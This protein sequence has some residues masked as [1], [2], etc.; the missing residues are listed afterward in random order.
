MTHCKQWWRAALLAAALTAGAGTWAADQ[1]YPGV[2][3]FSRWNNIPGTAVS[4]L[5]SNPR[6]PSSPDEITFPDIPDSGAN[7]GD[8]YGG[9]IEFLWSP[10]TSGSYQFAISADDNAEL[11][12]S[13][14]ENPANLVRVAIEPEWNGHRA[15]GTAE[16]RGG[17]PPGEGGVAACPNVTSPITFQAGRRYLFVGLWK[18]GGGGDSFAV[19]AGPAGTVFTDGMDPIPSSEIGVMASNQAAFLGNARSS[20]N[21]VYVGRRVNLA[22]NLYTPP[23]GTP[24]AVQWLKN[25]TPIPGGTGASYDYTAVAADAN[26][27]L[28]FSARLPD[29]TTSSTVTVRGL[30]VEGEVLSPGFLKIEFFTGIGGTAIDD[31]LNAPSF[32]NNQ[33]D[34]VSYLSAFDTPN[35][36]GDN[37]GARVTGFIIP[38]E[39]ADYHFFIRSDD[40]S[41]LSI[42]TDA[43][44]ANLQV[45]AQEFG[46]CQAFQEVD[47]GANQTT[48]APIRMVAGQRYYVEA[49][50]KEGGGGDYL[51]VAWRKANTSTPPAA[52]LQPIPGTFLATMAESGGV[53]INFTQQPPASLTI[54]ENRRATL[55]AA[56][57]AFPQ[58][59]VG[60]QWKKNGANIPGANA[61]S[62]TLPKQALA[63]SGAV[64]TVT[65]TTLANKSVTSAGTTVTVVPDTFP[66]KVVSAGSIRK[67]AA[68]EIGVV[69]DEEVNVASASNP[70]NYSL[71]AG[72][73]TGARYVKPKGTQLETGSV[74]LTASG[75]TAGQTVTLSVRNV[76]DVKG[77]AIPSGSPATAQVMVTGTLNWVAIGG[78]EINTARGTTDYGDDVVARGPSA[79]FENA[80]DFDLVSGGSANWNAYDEATF[81]YE[82]ITGNFD[83]VVRVEYQDPTSQ[84]A[85]AGLHVREALDEG[86]LRAD[87][88]GGPGVAAKPMSRNLSL[89]V[90]P[91]VRADGGP[92]NNGIETIDRFQT[93]GN[94][95][96]TPSGVPGGTP[97]PNL[98]L[99]V[100]RE[101]N[102]LR[103]WR[104]YDNGAT[105][106]GGLGAGL[107]WENPD[108]GEPPLAQ[109]LYV[110]IY[111]APEFFNNDT[112]N[113]LQGSA[114]A[115]FRD[116]GPWPATPIQ[117]DLGSLGISLSG[118][119][120]T[121]TWAAAGAR[122]QRASSV[123]GPWSDVTGAT[124]P[125]TTTVSGSEAYFRLTR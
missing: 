19:T 67:G 53:T 8:N 29:G 31:L 121:I 76:A 11:W 89:R 84:W 92:G 100:A 96:G 97:T 94:Y 30:P 17:C 91:A 7:I 38:A 3:K 39:T 23:G 107:N 52:Q 37:Y 98:W 82:E 122:L 125:H 111:Y 12:I 99:R 59:V 63:D 113:V 44:P 26:Q 115:Q 45:V 93:G 104:S 72:T 60:Y 95:R 58:N 56:A 41:Q 101:G 57:T 61:A 66:P 13:T 18:E 86:T 27:D 34:V 85:R 21:H 9:R 124:S 50:L 68:V 43:S 119:N 116:Y 62:Y 64:Y 74:V 70:A 114:V 123:N 73:I 49:L 24:A 35:G 106:Q 81:V 105:W 4:D 55:S 36:W 110:G 65:A 75:L 10:P 71:S 108:T 77:N 6:Y 40:A 120:V 54:E 46:C 33:P 48:A 103:A 22:V 25:G 109:K 69:F 78:D 16:R 88:E 112:Q 14:D 2:A 87:A 20:A 28:V 5:T 79:N 51:Q 102:V 47:L 15:F 118:G 90:N 80:Y 1:Y 117:Q 32:I 83:R 42:S